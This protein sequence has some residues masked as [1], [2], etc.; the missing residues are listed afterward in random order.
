MRWA[1]NMM[2]RLKDLPAVG[3]IT[4]RS[5][6]RPFDWFA[7]RRAVLVL[8]S[9][10]STRPSPRGLHTRSSESPRDS[11]SRGRG[12][13]GPVLP[14]CLPKRGSERGSRRSLLHPTPS[15]LCPSCPSR[16]PNMHTPSSTP[17]PLLASIFQ[18]PPKTE[19][20]K[21]PSL[22]V[23]RRLR[24][25]ESNAQTPY[26]PCPVVPLPSVASLS[27]AKQASE[28]RRASEPLACPLGLLARVR[29]R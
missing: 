16:A 22:P 3:K 28:E 27:D 29:R 9:D 7:A 10:P 6:C 20:T 4:G 24:P 12:A 14:A 17:S 21:R 8:A 19:C 5:S 15:P 25:T 1:S 13:K 23:F 2:K 11:V 26:L 18:T